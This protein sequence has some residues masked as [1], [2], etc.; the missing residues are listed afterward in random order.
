[1]QSL[2]SEEINESLEILNDAIAKLT[3]DFSIE[4]DNEKA[5]KLKAKLEL[6]EQYRKQ[7]TKGNISAIE[8]IIEEH[9]K[10]VI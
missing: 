7:A 10:G 3:N 5:K 8:H 9:H 2:K 1:M 6:L 4:K